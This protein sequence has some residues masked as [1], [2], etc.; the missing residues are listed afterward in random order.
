MIG[1]SPAWPN[2]GGAHAGYL[3]EAGGTRILLDCGPGVLT[4]LRRREP[5]PAPDA[6][7]VSHFHLDHFGD[8]V[9]W[10]WGL[11]HGPGAKTRTPLHVPPGGAA[12]LR[13]VGGLLGFAEMFEQTFALREYVSGGPFAVGACTIL[14]LPMR[15]YATPCHGLRVEQGGKV[16][17]YSADTGPAPTLVELARDA[18]LLLCEATL[19]SGAGDGEP[20]GHLSA[21][22]AVEF[23]REAGARR[24]VLTHRPVELP[25]PAGAELARDG[26]VLEV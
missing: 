22:E 15:H 13:R 8:L 5:W 4:R 25:V 16:L 23:A 19:R 7:V 9:P 1:S 21:E 3:V 11:L 12:H 24:L 10:A 20:R 14:P 17:A 6:I 2:P 26:L 18:D